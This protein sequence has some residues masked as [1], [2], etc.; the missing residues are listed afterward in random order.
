MKALGPQASGLDGLRAMRS[1][2][3]VGLSQTDTRCH[4]SVPCQCS[5]VFRD[6]CPS[7]G[8]AVVC[9]SLYVSLR[10]TVGAR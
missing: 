7:L 10:V 3:R 1:V 8:G 2:L 5:R 4:R 6:T 9:P